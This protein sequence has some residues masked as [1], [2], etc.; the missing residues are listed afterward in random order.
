VLRSAAPLVIVVLIVEEVVFD[1]AD[2]GIDLGRDV[3]N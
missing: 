1:Y 2:L 3:G